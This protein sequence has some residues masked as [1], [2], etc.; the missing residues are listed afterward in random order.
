LDEVLK[1]L[2]YGQHCARLPATLCAIAEQT[3]DH[4]QLIFTSFDPVKGIGGE[5]M[6]FD[7]DPNAEYEWDLSPDGT[8]IAV[9]KFMEGRIH[10]L[11][12]SGQ[13]AREISVNGWS[14]FEAL[15]W[16]ADG[17]GLLGCSRRQMISVLLHVD[18]QGRV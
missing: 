7:T 4:K 17:R 2:I 11:S 6:R 14:R 18:L 3:R 8:Q 10:V 1:A 16:A 13:L 9:H 15:H 5:L 12:L